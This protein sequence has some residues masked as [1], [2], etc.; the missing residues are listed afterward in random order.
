MMVVLDLEGRVEYLNRKAAETAGRA[1]EALTGA[2]WFGETMPGPLR[3]QAGET[4]RLLRGGEAAE[5]AVYL[6]IP[7]QR[8]DD[9][10]QRRIAWYNSVVRN[11]DGGVAWLVLSG[12]DVTEQ[13]DTERRLRN[14]RVQEEILNRLLRIGMRRASLHEK[15][16]DCLEAILTVPWI[17]L[18]PKGG[19]FLARDHDRVLELFVHK[20]LPVELQSMCAE[21]AYGHCLCGRAAQ[22]RRLVFA[23]RVDH[24]HENRYP[25]MAP[26]GHYV[27]PMLSGERLL[28][29]IVLY[30]DEAHVASDEEQAF[31]AAAAN[32]MAGI[33]ERS[34]AEDALRSSEQRLRTIVEYEA[35]GIL[36]VDGERRV[37]FSNPAAAEMLGRTAEALIGN[38]LPL[39]TEA[40]GELDLPCG[41]GAS[42]RAEVS[43]VHTHWDDRPARLV[44]LHDVTERRRHEAALR[45]QATHDALTGL[46][47]R[48]LFTDRL[49]QAVAHA[50][51]H[52]T[53]L[54]VLF[55][56]L[57]QFKLVNDGLGHEAGDA[58]LKAVAAGL[59]EECREGDTLARLGGD[60]FV[61]L[62]SEVGEPDDVVHLAGR[63]RHRLGASFT[64][65]GRELTITSS[66]GIALFP[67]DGDDGETLLRN[68]DAAM[69]RAKDAGR[70]TFQFYTRDINRDVN[71][72]LTL[73]QD[74]RSALDRKELFLLYQPQVDL[75]T[76]HVAG[77][78]ALVR[79]QHP[80][81]GLVMPDRFIPVAEESGLIVPLGEWVLGAACR[82]AVAWREADLPPVTMAVN[83]SARQFDQGRL[84]KVVRET[85]E[86]TGL[87]PAALELELTERLMMRPDPDQRVVLES[88][89]ED[90]VRIAVDDFGTG[91]SNLAQLQHFALDRLKIERAF[92]RN[93]AADPED[94][95][96]I[97]AI[98][99]MAKT[100]GLEVIAEGVETEVQA[101]FLAAKGCGQAQGFFFARPVPAEEVA[102]LLAAGASL[103]PQPAAADR[104]RVLV[105]DDDPGVARALQRT[106]VRVGY[107]VE[108]ATH[109]TQG[110]ERLA[111]TGF[112]AA[113]VDQ[114]MPEMTGVHFLRRVGSLYPETGRIAISAYQDFAEVTDAF[115]DG[116]IERFVAKPWEERDLVEAIEEVLAARRGAADRQA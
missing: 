44:V 33:L 68:A 48:S 43:E 100:L 104:P 37:V 53:R 35:N 74:L 60:E 72:R 49:D 18:R 16:T 65:A 115:N 51:R 41:D 63:L 92:V 45:H 69:Y 36:V 40:S 116:T 21:V 24:R 86:R 67:D 42:R 78:E 91:Y 17:A 10:R 30:L 99:G 81:R 73:A 114:R 76:G 39:D 107:R 4:F 54:A 88:L 34:R 5:P 27:A 14:S 112:A 20:D 82:Q 83:A 105:V 15:L 108:T 26:H 106:L 38:V 28:G 95:A 98:I 111:A 31:L 6:E 25:E 46:P 2:D 12:V 102:R 77:V 85:L 101:R 80:R 113:V 8:A 97:L 62:A 79:W 70:N 59:R 50:Q 103:L 109:P 96:I 57:D 29:V 71:E 47:N 58:L 1:A 89:R 7:M 75:V 94:A 23:D 84:E 52:R 19:V 64:V 3:G 13:H 93:L 56:D 22:E 55:I 87:P 32:T 90:G 61:V 11:D 66:I 9:G 110:F